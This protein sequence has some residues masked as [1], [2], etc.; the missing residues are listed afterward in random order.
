M[1]RD[2]DHRFVRLRFDRVGQ[3]RAL[4]QRQIP[5]GVA[6]QRHVRV[7]VAPAEQRSQAQSDREHDRLFLELELTVRADRAGVAT[8]VAG[9]DEDRRDPAQPF[10]RWEHLQR[11]RDEGGAEPNRGTF[12]ARRFD[13][14]HRGGVDGGDTQVDDERDRVGTAHQ[15][16]VAA[17]RV[18]LQ[19]GLRARH[20]LGKQQ[21]LRL[22]RRQRP[23]REHRDAACRQHD[24]DRLHARA[25]TTVS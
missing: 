21:R 7:G 25:P 19:P 4:L 13:R 1:E 22:L 24:A 5:I 15:R 6:R 8:A 18:P 9:I 12:T 17:H 23:N 11:A 3:A 16:A 10:T 20:H 14:E 2:E